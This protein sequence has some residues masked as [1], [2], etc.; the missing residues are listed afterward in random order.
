MLVVGGG[1]SGSRTAEVL[2]LPHGDN[3]RG[4]WTLLTQPLSRCF[5]RTFLVN[6]N[7]RIVAV[8]ELHINLV[9]TTSKQRLSSMNCLHFR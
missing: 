1:S 7:K 8:G 6:F 2:Q 9:S 5:Y 3:D 4:V